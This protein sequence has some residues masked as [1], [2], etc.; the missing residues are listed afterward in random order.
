MAEAGSRNKCLESVGPKGSRI[1]YWARSV[2]CRVEQAEALPGHREGVGTWAVYD[3]LG[4]A[5]F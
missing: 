4:L 2:W 5:F 1:N 3:P